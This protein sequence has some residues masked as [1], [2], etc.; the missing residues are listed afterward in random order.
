M[1]QEHM[2]AL[3]MKP[4]LPVHYAVYVVLIFSFIL[5]SFFP[6]D[7]TLSSKNRAVDSLD[8]SFNCTE[9]DWSFLHFKQLTEN[10]YSC[11]IK[12]LKTMQHNDKPQLYALSHATI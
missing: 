10:I 6:I 4:K 12:K 3:W 9:L 7:S 5:V 2:I 11:I 8:F 1:D